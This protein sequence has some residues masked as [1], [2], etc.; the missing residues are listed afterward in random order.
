MSYYGP[1]GAPNRKQPS[2][3]STALL[4]VGGIIIIP[5]I[6]GWLALGFVGP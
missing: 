3:G 4:W 2:A 1:G 6:I 5:W